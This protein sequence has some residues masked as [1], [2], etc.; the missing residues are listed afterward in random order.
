MI[1]IPHALLG[2]LERGTCLGAPLTDTGRGTFT[3]SGTP[4]TDQE[5]L[6]QLELPGHETA[7]EVAK[8]KE[9]RPV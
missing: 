9:I 8:G 1:E 7:I 2:F 6:Q 4:V 3:L 5:A